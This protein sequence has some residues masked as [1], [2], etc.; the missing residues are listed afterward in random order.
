MAVPDEIP[1]EFAQFDLVVIHL[2]NNLGREILGKLFEFRGQVY[3]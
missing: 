1:A 2:G 3:R